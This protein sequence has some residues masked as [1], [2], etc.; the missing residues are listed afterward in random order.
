MSKFHYNENNKSHNDQYEGGFSRMKT[1]N[2]FNADLLIKSANKKNEISNKPSLEEK[3]V[4][5]NLI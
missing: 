2:F 3:A 1:N 4:L 5:T